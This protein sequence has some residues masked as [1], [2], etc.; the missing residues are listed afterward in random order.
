M[1]D[2]P[3]KVKDEPGAKERFERAIKNALGTPA[4]PHKTNETKRLAK[5]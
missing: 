4:K 2:K 1:T 5:G 3:S